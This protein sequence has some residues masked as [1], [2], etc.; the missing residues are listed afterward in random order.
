M[1]DEAVLQRRV[2]ELDETQE[3]H[4]RRITRLERWRMEMRG[5]LKVL[6]FIIG[7]GAVAYVA[8]LIGVV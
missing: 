6:A 2:K 5:A 1:V 7:S 4:E 3:H 8:D